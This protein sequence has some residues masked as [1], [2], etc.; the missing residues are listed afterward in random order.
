[1]LE[2][3]LRMGFTPGAIATGLK[4]PRNYFNATNRDF[5]N[6]RRLKNPRRRAHRREAAVNATNL[7]L[8]VRAILSVGQHPRNRV[9]K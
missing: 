6:T 8:K 5:K 9:T 7:G 2:V 1:M 3:Q 4:R